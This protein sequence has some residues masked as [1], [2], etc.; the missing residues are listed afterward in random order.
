MWVFVLDIELL[1]F[2]P[3]QILFPAVGWFI[4]LLI[5]SELKWKLC[6]P[7]A[8][9]NY[10]WDCHLYVYQFTYWINEIENSLCVNG[11]VVTIMS[12]KVN[13]RELLNL[14]WLISFLLENF[15]LFC[16]NSF[17]GHVSS[18]TMQ[19][20]PKFSCF[21][22]VLVAWSNL[23][24]FMTGM[25]KLSLKGT[26]ILST[27]FL[28]PLMQHW[29]VSRWNP[30]VIF[31]YCISLGWSFSTSKFGKSYA[32]EKGIGSSPLERI[33]IPGKRGESRTCLLHSKIRSIDVWSFL[34]W[35]IS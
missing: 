9:W 29:E 13:P 31:S 16:G 6:F 18:S 17:K 10:K 24:L 14:W 7:F 33:L 2:C 26:R 20:T 3:I 34:F 19:E 4:G 21:C 25:F 35:V 15:M 8:A 22:F 1:V 11:Y 32:L 30:G 28:M 23:H 5:Q 27:Q 12:I